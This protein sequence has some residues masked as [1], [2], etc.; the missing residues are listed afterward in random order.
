MQSDDCR[1]VKGSCRRLGGFPCNRNKVPITPN[2]FKDSTTDEKQ[3]CECWDKS[4]DANIGVP[5]GEHSDLLVLDID[6]PKGPKSLEALTEKH[7]D[8]SPTLTARTGSGGV[9]YYFKHLSGIRNSS[10]QI[11]KGI[12]IRGDGGVMSLSHPQKTATGRKSGL[13]T[14][15]LLMHPLGSSI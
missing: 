11:A 4:P 10:G 1:G 7:G 9:H 6:L 8:L 13:N 3:V 5:T 14:N 12:D 2:G 15:R